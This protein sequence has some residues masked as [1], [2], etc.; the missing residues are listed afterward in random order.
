M[1]PFL[2]TEK[3]NG[4]KIGIWRRKH[5]V[6][7]L[8]A[9]AVQ[10]DFCLEMGFCSVEDEVEVPAGQMPPK[11]AA[12]RWGSLL[13]ARLWERTKWMLQWVHEQHLFDWKLT[14]WLNVVTEA[15]FVTLLSF[16]FRCL[17]QFSFF[18]VLRKHPAWLQCRQC[19]WNQTDMSVTF[20]FR[21]L[22]RA[23]LSKLL[24]LG[25]PQRDASKT[26]QKKR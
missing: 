19:L 17:Q 7:I 1:V 10:L 23:D 6:R 8:G 18:Y 12:R 3:T 24:T 11:N 13:S 16:S 20:L 9:H 22:A 2:S 5:L 4:G 14:K 25:T 26:S 15:R 21:Q